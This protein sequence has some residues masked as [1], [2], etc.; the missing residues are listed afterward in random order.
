MVRNIVKGMLVGTDREI[1]VTETGELGQK[2]QIGF[3]DDA[4]FGDYLAN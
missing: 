1:K 4:I 2:L 3:A